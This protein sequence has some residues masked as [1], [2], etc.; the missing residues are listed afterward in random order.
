MKTGCTRASVM[1]SRGVITLI[2]CAR[3][4]APFAKR[5][6]TRCG[7]NANANRKAALA[8]TAEAITDTENSHAR[9]T[10]AGI[11]RITHARARAR[12]I[13]NSRLAIAG[14][15]R[16]YWR[17][18]LINEIQRDS[19]TARNMRKYYL[20]RARQIWCSYESIQC[21]Y[22]RSSNGRHNITPG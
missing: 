14:S 1:E 15:D 8:F 12:A 18:E 20:P 2:A 17:T 7:R 19:A 3:G 13:E 4:R 21:S 5:I 6:E 9:A 10:P 22:N 16:P 11:A